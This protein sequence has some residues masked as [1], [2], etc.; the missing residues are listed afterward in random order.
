MSDSHKQRVEGEDPATGDARAEAGE[1]PSSSRSRGRN[2]RKRKKKAADVPQEESKPSAGNPPKE[3]VQ[4]KAKRE[5]KM[6]KPRPNM[7]T[8]LQVNDPGIHQRLLR[9]QK[10]ALESDKKLKEFM[11]P[12][13]KAHITL[14]AFY[15][16]ETSIPYLT[17]AVERGVEAWEREEE[18][19]DQED[20][21]KL[22]LHF[23]GLGTF[24][25][26]VYNKD[27]VVFA[28][29]QENASLERLYARVTEKMGEVEGM[30]DQLKPDFVPHLT[31]MK[32]SRAKSREGRKRRRIEAE[33]Y[34]Q[35]IDID[36]GTQICSS[37]QLLSMT[38]PPDPK[39]GYY[40]S[41]G[42]VRLPGLQHTFKREMHTACCEPKLQKYKRA[43]AVVDKDSAAEEE[44][45]NQDM[46]IAIEKEEVRVTF[47]ERVMDML[48]P[49]KVREAV[50]SPKTLFLC[51]ALAFA[52]YK[53][54]S[55]RK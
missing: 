16:E 12:V 47:R 37:L 15:L 14:H 8:A 6:K 19:Q 45:D 25:G 28:K 43:A 42:E 48:S 11:V 13:N 17:A 22:E 38:K 46:T 21:G 20:Q 53:I 10:S 52:A 31:I 36:F 5:K 44:K 24:T 41:L 49:S 7:F 51:A 18:G 27:K 55:Y 2:H 30:G 29:M 3:E 34:E 50:C 32:L 26:K 4:E 23:S 33:H 40:S 39:T 35:F 1:G 9:V 54:K